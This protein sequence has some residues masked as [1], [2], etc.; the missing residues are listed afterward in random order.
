[1]KS[2]KERSIIGRS[3]YRVWYGLLKLGFGLLY[4]Q[5]AWSYDLVSWLVSRGE[6]RNWQ[7]AGLPSLHGETILELAHG[8]GHMLLALQ[9]AGHEVVGLDLSP[10]MSR[11]ASRRAHD[12]R[13]QVALVRGDG[14]SLPFRDQTFDGV[15]STFPTEFLARPATIDGI[16]RVLKA[17]GRL[18][19]VPQARLTGGSFLTRFIEWLYAIT[20]QRPEATYD[21]QDGFWQV[22]GNRF[23][24]AGFLLTFEEV[25][26]ER[27][28]VM[29]VVAEKP[30]DDQ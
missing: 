22:I 17:G 10:A 21:D 30:R 14:Q 16:Y 1:V 20:G 13:A 9:G 2:Q 12:A 15:L 23:R 25:S 6:W 7:R 27:S 24:A 4:N 28:R 5:M 18:V 26:L 3:V 8:P 29:V 19:V 11:L